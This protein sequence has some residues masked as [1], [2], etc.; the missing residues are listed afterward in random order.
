[1]KAISCCNGS[2][3]QE[4]DITESQFWRR[5][6]QLSVQAVTAVLTLKKKYMFV[7]VATLH[8][9][10]DLYFNKFVVFV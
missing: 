6:S 2:L 1:M 5:F 4:L 7:S 9:E 8:E 3:R 10:R